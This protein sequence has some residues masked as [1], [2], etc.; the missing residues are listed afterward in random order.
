MKT[1]KTYFIVWFIAISLIFIQNVSLNAQ[2]PDGTYTRTSKDFKVILTCEARKSN[3]Q[4][5][6]VRLDMS[7]WEQANL[8]NKNGQLINK[9]GYVKRNG[10]IPGGSYVNSCRNIKVTLYATCKKLNGQWQK[11]SLNISNYRN[12]DIVNRDGQ[13]RIE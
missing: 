11:S 8:E 12:G 7:E 3:G 13:L 9:S 5:V 10:Y 4:W 2:I 1:I 6:P